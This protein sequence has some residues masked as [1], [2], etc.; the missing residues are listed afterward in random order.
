MGS[1]ANTLGNFAW[2]S[3]E[4]LAKRRGIE[5]R[6]GEHA[7]AALMTPRTARKVS[8]GALGSGGE[9]CID[10][11]EQFVHRVFVKSTS[12]GT[13]PVRLR[14]VGGFVSTLNDFRSCASSQGCQAS[15]EHE[16]IGEDCAERSALVY[17]RCFE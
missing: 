4:A 2:C 8:A 14:F 11:G 17:Y 1:P 9:R 3:G 13:I 12:L 15:H 16:H 7:N 10:D 5:C 6:N